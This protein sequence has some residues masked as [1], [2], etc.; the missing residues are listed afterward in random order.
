MWGCVCACDADDVVNKQ[1]AEYLTHESPHGWGSRGALHLRSNEPVVEAPSPSSK[2]SKWVDA[3]ALD[4]RDNETE[5]LD[6]APSD[7]AGFFEVQIEEEKRCD[8]PLG[9]DVMLAS[10]TLVVQKVRRGVL[11]GHNV[12]S[13]PFDSVFAH[14][15]ILEVNGT[16][17]PKEM[18]NQLKL[19]S[20]TL[21]MKLCHPSHVKIEVEKG[22][23]E[24]G[25]RLHCHSAGASLLEVL[26]IYPG[27]VEYRNSTTSDAKERIRPLDFIASVNGITLDVQKMI[28]ELKVSR[29][30]QLKLL[31]LPSE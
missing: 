18:L 22:D 6:T 9:I 17:E 11:L 29:T 21:N 7:H 5:Y 28:E 26:E 24:L 2:R 8:K 19:S 23:R 3:S 25:L 20:Q 16:R 12:C 1:G 14:D 27:A 30:L 31:R 15:L 4:E 10:M 13:M